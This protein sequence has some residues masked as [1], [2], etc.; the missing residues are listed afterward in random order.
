MSPRRERFQAELRMSVGSGLMSVHLIINETLPEN[1][2]V[3]V[4]GVSTFAPVCEEVRDLY[5]EE[6]GRTGCVT[7]RN[8]PTGRLGQANT[9]QQDSPHLWTG[10]VCSS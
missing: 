6:E 5:G 8:P 3:Q 10:L 4:P 9:S 7:V 1:L 2:V